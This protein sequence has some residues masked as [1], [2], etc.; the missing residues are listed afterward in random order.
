MSRELTDAERLNWLSERIVYF[1]YDIDLGNGSILLESP[2]RDKINLRAAIDRAALREEQLNKE[3]K[4][5]GTCKHRK[6]CCR[7][8]QK[9]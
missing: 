6:S 8:T 7:N 2:E 5:K 9:K 3:R 4:E 1:N